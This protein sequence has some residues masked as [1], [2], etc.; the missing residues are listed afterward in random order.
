MVELRKPLALASAIGLLCGLA[1]GPALA[2][3]SPWL[4]EPQTGSMSVVYV[5]QKADEK[6][7]GPGGTVHGPMPGGEL[8]QGTLWLVGDYA[9]RDNIA[10]DGQVGWARS[11]LAADSDSGLA[12]ANFG[13]TWRLM[14]ELVG[15]PLSVAVRGGV[16]LAGNYD[17]G[18]ALPTTSGAPPGIYALGDGGSG[19]EASVH[20][21]KVFAQ[22]LGVAGELGHRRRGNDIPANTFFNLSA[23]LLASERVTLAVDYQRVDTNGELDIGVPPFNPDRFP[24]VAEE[25]TVVG[26]RATVNLTDTAS[27]TF[28]YGDTI[29]GRNTSDSRILGVSVSY[30]FTNF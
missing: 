29:D 19:V 26:G 17:T 27:A 9:L 12:D 20:V 6:W 3:G 1:S 2:A 24:E 22:R 30:G 21:G 23:F 4:A 13:V 7:T 15:Q 28:F 16:I 18:F 8:T 5:S 10:I 14:D 25:T 11:E